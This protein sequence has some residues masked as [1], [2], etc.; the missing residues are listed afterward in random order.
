MTGNWLTWRLPDNVTIRSEWAVR[1]ILK[2]IAFQATFAYHKDGE[3]AKAFVVPL[4]VK[5]FGYWK[6]PPNIFLKINIS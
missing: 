1:F 4:C 3:D 6:E 5:M 2:Y